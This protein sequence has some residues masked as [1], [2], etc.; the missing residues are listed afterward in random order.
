MYT[1]HGN[2]EVE[3]HCGVFIA[4]ALPKL[5]EL[6]IQSHLPSMCPAFQVRGIRAKF[7]TVLRLPQVFADDG[8]LR[9][10]ISTLYPAPNTL[11]TFRP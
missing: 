4:G 10:S 2:A 8:M 9:Y 3:Q 7:L 6:N 11:G 1:M 5:Q